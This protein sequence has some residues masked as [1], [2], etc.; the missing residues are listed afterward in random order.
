G[1]RLVL[2]R[3]EGLPDRVDLCQPVRGQRG[4]ELLLKEL[5]APHEA[6]KLGL[7]LPRRRETEGKVVQRGQE[8]LKEPGRREEPELLLFAHRP[9]AEVLEVGRGA[10]VPVAVLRRLLPR[11]R[12]RVGL[13]RRALLRL[14]RRSLLGLL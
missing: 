2:V 1:D 8:V 7:R 6:S 4:L 10:Q 12:K 5:H 13:S 11:R 9:A 3:V 14:R